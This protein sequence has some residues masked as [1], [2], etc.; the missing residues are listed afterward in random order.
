M[1]TCSFGTWMPE[2]TI[3]RLR[4][5]LWDM[6]RMV[7]KNCACLESIWTRRFKKLGWIK[8]ISVLFHAWQVCSGT[9]GHFWSIAIWRRECWNSWYAGILPT[10]VLYAHCLRLQGHCE[11]DMW[12]RCPASFCWAYW[13]GT[14]P[15][16]ARYNP[17]W[18]CW[19][20][21]TRWFQA[22]R[23]LAYWPKRRCVITNAT[24]SGACLKSAI[25]TGQEIP[26]T[27]CLMRCN[28]IT[29]FMIGHR[30]CAYLELWS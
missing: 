8:E 9:A 3:S 28:E 15:N 14:Y 21:R 30:I 24:M 10:L 25:D 13:K 7:W 5:E 6:A 11:T 22:H 19:K 18:Y 16:V 23:F 4:I 17:H 20:P 26:Q 27:Q 29:A 12:D 1:M 2:S